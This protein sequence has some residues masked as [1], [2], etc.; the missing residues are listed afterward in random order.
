MRFTVSLGSNRGGVPVLAALTRYRCGSEEHNR[1]LY[2]VLGRRGRHVF[3][4][5]PSRAGPR[6]NPIFFTPKV[7]LVQ[8]RSGLNNLDHR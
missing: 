5:C 6:H 8:R 7:L 1:L 2:V 3:G 4:W